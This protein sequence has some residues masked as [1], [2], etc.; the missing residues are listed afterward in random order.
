MAL[1]SVRSAWEATREASSVTRAAGA[2]AKTNRW[3]CRVG[4]ACVRATTVAPSV[5][6][7]VAVVAVIIVT[8][9]TVATFLLLGAAVSVIVN[10]SIV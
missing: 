6:V 3:R 10:V 9:P 4:S 8:T 7:A 1:C 5:G 2:G